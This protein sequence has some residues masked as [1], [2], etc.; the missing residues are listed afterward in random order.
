MWNAFLTHAHSRLYCSDC[1]DCHVGADGGAEAFALPLMVGYVGQVPKVLFP[2][3]P[4]AAAG[5]SGPK[6][7]PSSKPD[8]DAKAAGGAGGPLAHRG[9][10]T[11]VGRVAAGRAGT[12]WWRAGLDGK[13]GLY[14]YY[15]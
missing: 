5:P 14:F 1:T 8:P 4:P 15:F 6:P 10:I 12:R 2:V 3:Q 11:V 9:C 7:K 13:V